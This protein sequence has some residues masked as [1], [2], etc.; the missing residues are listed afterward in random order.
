MYMYIF[1]IIV[2]INVRQLTGFFDYPI[3]SSN[4]DSCCV[5]LKPYKDIHV[6]KIT[7]G[8]MI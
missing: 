1:V 7:Y 8:G 5:C 2:D 3:S 4:R 6:H